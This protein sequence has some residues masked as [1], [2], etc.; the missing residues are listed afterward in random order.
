MHH[1]PGSWL[2]G[3]N[4]KHCWH[5]SR[6]KLLPLWSPVVLNGFCV[7][8]RYLCLRHLS[9][10]F[11]F[12]PTDNYKATLV[13][14]ALF[15][16]VLYQTNHRFPMSWVQPKQF[17]VHVR[18]V[19]H[20]QCNS[21]VLVCLFTMK[22]W[23]GKLKNNFTHILSPNANN[24]PNLKAKEIAMIL[25]KHKWNYSL[26]SWAYHS[27]MITWL[28]ISWVT[29]TLTIIGFDI[30]HRI[31]YQSRTL[32]NEHFRAWILAEVDIVDVLFCVFRFSTV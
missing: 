19:L 6:W 9:S 3:F 2:L 8:C 23:W 7:V 1:D 15:I 11:F 32:C 17:R 14:L 18:R 26:F 27:I 10:T 30:V 16:F 29:N 28:L 31:D 21:V 13:Y 5:Y 24:F 25:T 22:W 20:V 12:T 4:P